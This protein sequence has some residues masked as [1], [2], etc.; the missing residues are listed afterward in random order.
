MNLSPTIASVM[1]YNYENGTYEQ[2][3]SAGNARRSK[4]RLRSSSTY[5][6]EEDGARRR[7]NPRGSETRGTQWHC[8]CGHRRPGQLHL[9][10]PCLFCSCGSRIVLA[11]ILGTLTLLMILLGSVVVILESSKVV[12]VP[13]PSPILVRFYFLHL[14]SRSSVRLCW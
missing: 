1:P 4:I 8:Q 3:G 10:C 2:K 6:W 11:L 5:V 7:R 9:C 12:V 14:Q 13:R